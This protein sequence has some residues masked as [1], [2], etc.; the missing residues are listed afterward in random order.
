MLEQNE[1]V[2][3]T[4]DISHTELAGHKKNINNETGEK[5]EGRKEIFI[6]QS[7]HN[8]IMVFT[9]V[10]SAWETITKTAM[11]SLL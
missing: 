4:Y 10:V 7:I 11:R 9:I 5:E 3:T 1:S 8:N 6:W 2:I